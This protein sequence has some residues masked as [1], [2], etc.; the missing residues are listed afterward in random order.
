MTV[1]VSTGVLDSGVSI[2]VFNPRLDVDLATETLALGGVPGIS[3]SYYQRVY[4]S[5]AGFV[6]YT[7]TAVNATP[8]STATTPN[9]TNNLV[10][11][12][13]SVIARL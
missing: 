2:R 3:V 5:T 6:Y 1:S 9:H 4:D 10:A 7:D 8:L 13:H 12:T 11:G